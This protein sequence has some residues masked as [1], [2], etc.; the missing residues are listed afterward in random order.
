M[1][2]LTSIRVIGNKGRAYSLIRAEKASIPTTVHNLV[3]GKYLKSGETDLA[4][5]AAARERYDA[6]PA[7]MILADSPDIVVCAGWMLISSPS[8]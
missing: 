2:Y 4:I 7:N 6:D 5:R 3:T 8:F 1:P